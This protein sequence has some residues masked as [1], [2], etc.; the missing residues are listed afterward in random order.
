[1]SVCRPL[2]SIKIVL[3]EIRKVEPIFFVW[4]GGLSL[5]SVNISFGK[6]E[7]LTFSLET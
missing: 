3:V 2:N 1:M 5:E 6:K 4:G 7:Q